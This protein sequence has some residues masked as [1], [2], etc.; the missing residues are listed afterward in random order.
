[1][2][3]KYKEVVSTLITHNRSSSR[4][5]GSFLMPMI[6]CL[7]FISCHILTGKPS[8]NFESSPSANLADK[9]SISTIQK[10]PIS[11]QPPMDHPS[12][13]LR[14]LPEP[15]SCPEAQKKFS[16]RFAVQ[17][18][19]GTKRLG[20]L[21]GVPFAFNSADSFHS[22]KGFYATNKAGTALPAQFEVLSR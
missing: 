2:L 21:I 17:E 8:S 7:G 12:A 1:M 11:I 22:L 14:M 4:L 5:P 9:D 13:T 18:D 16:M 19:F 6:F 3:S 15:D 10:R 20:Q